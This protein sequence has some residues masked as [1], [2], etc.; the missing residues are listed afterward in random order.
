MRETLAGLAALPGNQREALLR[1]A[2]GGD[3]RAQVAHDLG[4]TD[5]AV[6]QL[7]HRARVTLRAAATAVTP[8]PVAIWA[9][10]A[11]GAG[12]P[13][14]ARI[15][16]LGAAGGAGVLLK[17]G[18]VLVA[19]GVLVT[20]PVALRDVSKHNRIGPDAAAANAPSHTTPAAEWVSNGGTSGARSGTGT[21]GSGASS[22]R[23]GSGDHSGRHGRSGDS[24]GS[25]G[26]GT[27]SDDRSGSGGSGR[28]GSSGGDGR[29]GSGSDHSASGTPSDSGSDHSGTG[30]PEPPSG[31]GA[32][33]SAPEGGTP[34]ADSSHR[35]GG[36]DHPLVELP[37]PPHD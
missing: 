18:A 24:S 25:S 36:G 22:H 12:E 37:E 4:L 23:T 30:S 17:G 14:A 34:P 16:E 10:G 13:T 21:G 9:A 29:R 7:V 6:R 15:A 35:S 27:S 5:G 33:S 3:S 26:S 2:V 19:A 28:E 32:P 8:A 20:G 31:G 1:T 11:V